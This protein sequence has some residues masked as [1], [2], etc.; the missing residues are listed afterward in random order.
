MK[1][2]FQKLI[3]VLFLCILVFNISFPIISHAEV[4][5]D[6]QFEDAKIDDSVLGTAVDG[7]IG[8]LT[9]IF[10]A[11]IAASF[12]FYHALVTQLC[13]IQG[14]NAVLT[15]EDIIFTGS[16]RN[17]QA[18]IININFFD[19]TGSGAN[20]SLVKNF[21]L[22]V[23]KWYYVLRNIS[24]VLSLAVLIYIGI[25]MAI[26]SVAS[27]KAMYKTM[28]INWT[29]GFVILFVLHYIIIIVLKLNNALVDLIYS[30]S[31]MN[32][33]GIIEDYMSA[34]MVSSF[35]PMFVRGVG[36]LILY[37]IL[38]G[39]TIALFIM[40]MKR[41]FT[42]GFLIVISPLITIT[43]SVDKLGDGKSQALDTWIKEFVYN[44]LIQPFHCIIYVIFV[45]SSINT[46]NSSHSLG[47]IIFTVFS[48]LFIFKA[49]NIVRK[50][51]G[52]EKASSV[53]GMMAAGALFAN[54]IGKI[55]SARQKSQKAA[56]KANSESGSAGIQRK[57]IPSSGNS[58]SASSSGTSSNAG[59]SNI[60]SSGTNSNAGGST[61]SSS[62][63]NNGGQNKQ[64]SAFA[65][66]F[67]D[68]KNDVKSGINEFVANPKDAMGNLGKEALLRGV[69]GAAK[70]A[71]KLAVG[72][73]LAGATGNGLNGII[74][75]YSTI[76]GKFTNKISS[77]ADEDLHDLK[78]KTQ[79]KRLA[80]AYD[81]FRVANSDLSD[82]ELYNKAADLLEA[83]TDLL[84]NSNDIALAKQ[85][86]K[87]NDL[88]TEKGVKNPEDRVMNKIENIQAGNIKNSVNIRLDN[89]ENA[90]KNF[91]DNSPNTTD[92]DV[93]KMSKDIIADIEKAKRDQKAYL[94]NSDFKDLDKE[95]K[96]LAK[97]IYKSKEVLGAIG[98]NNNDA[99]NKEIETAIQK[100]LS[101]KS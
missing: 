51:F 87:M 34:L 94:S 33:S 35:S 57:P 7:I 88:Y 90:V 47:T 28:L 68:M 6:E 32:S 83:D 56:G 96:E 37:V 79:G 24:I 12:I 40:Y 48:V 66:A 27:D 53:E 69:S 30:V 46:L 67:S 58:Y 4:N 81:K 22:G 77:L 59:G 65:R 93:I 9:W 1:K 49:E 84:S 43:Y 19:F 80:A 78:M 100:G 63:S 18:N 98:D 85:L 5:I 92:Q 101:R 8:V 76:G 39:T 23:A 73:M 13:G 44:V 74:A 82:D 21:R 41:L 99:I 10:R 25:R 97:T 50:I 3:I 54:G 55:S 16:S 26:S 11:P 62:F 91:R 86:Q 38:I 61:A 60:N 42:V 31:G 72:G 52:F 2:T 75:G 71:P 36:S 15:A 14:D 45:S 89:V 17:Q 29:I 64:S 95:K 20:D 70:I